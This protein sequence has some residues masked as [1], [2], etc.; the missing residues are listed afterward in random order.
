MAEKD[1]IAGEG[2]SLTPHPTLP[3]VEVAG[4]RGEAAFRDELSSSSNPLLGSGMVAHNDALS[5]PVGSVG[6][7]LAALTVAVG[8]GGGGGGGAAGQSAYVHIRYS[9]DGGVTFT[10]AGG[11][12]PGTHLGTT[13]S[14]SPT[15]PAAVGAYSWALIRGAQGPAGPTGAAG[16]TGAQGAQGIQGPAGPTGQ[17]TYFHVA[18]AENATGTTGFNSVGGTYIG[19]YSD[20]NIADSTNPADY[21]WRLFRG[22][23]GPQGTQGIAGTPG[24]NGQTPYLH[25]KYS[26]DGGLSFTGNQGEDAGSWL[27]QYVDFTP[28][29]STSLAAYTWTRIRGDQGAT[30]PQGAT[31]AAG[32]AGATGAQGPQGIQ[33][34]TGASGQTPYF[35]VAF[36]SN[37]TGTIGFNQTSGAFIG[38]YV[39]FSPTDS[40]N[41]ASYTWRQFQGAQG[42]TG[43]QGIPGV[44][45]ANGQTSYVHIKYSNDGGTTFTASQGEVPGAFIGTYVDFNSA[46]S[47]SPAAYTWALIQGA[48]GATGAPGAAGAAGANGQTSYVHVKWSNDGGATFTTNQGEDPGAYIGV[49]TDF[50]AADP[51]NPAAYTWALVRGATGATG[52]QG[53]AGPNG[54]PSYLHIKWSNDGGVTFT[55]SGGETP[56]AWIGTYTDSNP[57]DSTSVSAYTWALV[58]GPQGAAGATGATGAAGSSSFVATVFIQ[59]TGTPSAPTGGS[60]SFATGTVTAPSGW[61]S[62]RPAYSAQAG[63]WASSFTFSTTSPGSTVAGGTWSPPVKI[64]DGASSSPVRGFSVT[65]SRS[66]VGSSGTASATVSLL[67]DGTITTQR[68][69]FAPVTAAVSWFSPP[70]G[71]VGASY[72]VVA[73][74]SGVVSLTG[75]GLNTPISLASAATWT[76]SLST[77][78]ELQSY[79]NFDIISNATGLIV[80]SGSASL[81]VVREP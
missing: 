17:R 45:G 26:N 65:V 40:T 20:T 16:A 75:S 19:T 78:G 28:A 39:D 61:V 79:L 77:L 10:G 35:H 43:A 72:Q 58:Q 71:G 33:G 76:L 46:D 7:K 54:L 36:A 56:G 6:A 1:L 47:L 32:P 73:R 23:Q 64:D 34:P 81:A 69:G 41:P 13:T 51:T 66:V 38:T 12:T 63:T 8:G 50:N 60:Y 67:A 31:G 42:P 22:A 11:T 21:T 52:I 3:Q 70:Q 57:A 27:G 2:I 9:N 59:G 44:N 62:Q 37:S 18:Y 48:Q 55:A 5:Y 30:G 29:D 53:P 49:V 4:K 74:A 15:A 24:A 25:L 14:N 68:S 80:G